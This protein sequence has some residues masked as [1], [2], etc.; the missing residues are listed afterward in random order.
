MKI[1]AWYVRTA[2]VLEYV[3][4]GEAYILRSHGIP[5]E[6]AIAL[7]LIQPVMVFFVKKENDQ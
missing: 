4:S 7:R 1:F 5:N 3:T 6:Y 2:P